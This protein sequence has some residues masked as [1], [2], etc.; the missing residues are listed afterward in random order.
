MLPRN[1]TITSPISREK[2]LLDKCKCLHV[3][4]F[5]KST[6]NI[7]Y[8]EG[9]MEVGEGLDYTSQQIIN[10]RMMNSEIINC[11]ASSVFIDNDSIINMDMSLVSI[12]KDEISFIS[13]LDD[14]R[15]SEDEDI[16]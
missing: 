7:L 8:I 13:I 1:Y 16:I 10:Y 11:I 3:K 12:M 6:S 2:R 15:L 14:Y 4:I 5:L 9:Y